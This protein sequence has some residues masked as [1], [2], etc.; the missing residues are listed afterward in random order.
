[1]TGFALSGHLLD[2]AD[3]SQVQIELNFS[4]I[5]LFKKTLELAEKKKFPTRL[6]K[7]NK[8]TYS[9]RVKVDPKNRETE[10]MILYDPQ[11]SG[12]LLIF[13]RESQA[14]QMVS[15]LRGKGV[16]DASIIGRVSDSDS[17]SII[18]L[19]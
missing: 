1:M 8:E 6:T 10:E 14:N 4:S 15:E 3:A 7:D 19:P 11:T 16:V 9:H 5:P 18:L 12:G 2:V 17:P 13:V